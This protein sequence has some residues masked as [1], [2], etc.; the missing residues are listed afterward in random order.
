MLHV[1]PG[2]IADWGIGLPVPSHDVGEQGALV[3]AGAGTF[4]HRII[5]KID[6]S[7]KVVARG[8]VVVES[9][10][11]GDVTPEGGVADAAIEIKNFRLILLGQLNRAGEPV[12][13]PG[14]AHPTPFVVG[15][16]MRIVHPGMGG[17]VKRRVLRIV[18]VR[19]NVAAVVV[20][21]VVLGAMRRETEM[22]SSG[23]GGLGEVADDVAMRAHFNGRPIGEVGVVHGKSVV[24]LGD[25]DYVLGAG[26]FEEINPVGGVP[27]FGA[28]FGNEIFV[29][30]IFQRAVIS[31]EVFIRRVARPVH[32]VGIPFIHRPGNG[33]N[34][35]GDE[36]SEL[37]VFIPLRVYKVAEG[38]PVRAIGA[39]VGL[40]VG[41]GDE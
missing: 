24:V 38:F 14:F 13:R 4:W 27:F 36:D 15:D 1:S 41:F 7:R 29:A 6:D 32:V 12:A 5:F 9:G 17:P 31:L 16:E 10:K 3:V 22:Q 23:A 2:K 8:V 34:S 28:E 19:A 35:P 40:V 21:V 37:G 26:A 33:I 25:R 39:V 18:H 30:D 11:L 20:I